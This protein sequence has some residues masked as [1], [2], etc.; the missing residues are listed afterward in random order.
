MGSTTEPTGTR[1]RSATASGHLDRRTLVLSGALLAGVI[2][3]GVVLVAV[4][5]EDGPRQDTQ[6]QLTEAGGAK[7][8]IIPRPNEGRAP[9]DPGDRGGW[10]QLTLFGLLAAALTG[11]GF[12]VFRG[13]ASA[14][15][16]RAAWRAAAATGRDGA[17]DRSGAVAPSPTP[18]PRT[19]GDPA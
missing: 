13:G 2:L 9:E 1:P 19:G 10:E 12:A 18:D 11:I 17:V 5:A 8:H 7:P 3:A 14:R 4:T 16:N 6:G 15:A